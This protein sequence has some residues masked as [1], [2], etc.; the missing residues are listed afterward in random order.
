MKRTKD[1]ASEPRIETLEAG[2][3]EKEQFCKDDE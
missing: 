1:K 2:S 3:D